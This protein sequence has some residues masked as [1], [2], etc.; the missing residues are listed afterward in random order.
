MLFE[1]LF[2]MVRINANYVTGKAREDIPESVPPSA[3][4]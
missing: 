4:N 3:G 1:N 2:Q